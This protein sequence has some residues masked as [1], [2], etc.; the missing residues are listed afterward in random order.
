M[1]RLHITTE[2][3]TEQGFVRRVLAE[4]LAG[5]HVFV[6]AR[7]ILTSRDKRTAKEY[8]GG[9]IGYEKAKK[10][11]L[12][13]IKEDNHPECRFTTM[14]DLYALPEDFPG[15]MVAKNA[16]D[17]YERTNVLE[18]AMARDIN[19]PRFIPYIQLHEFEALILS[20]PRKLDG[21]YLEHE[22]QIENLIAMVDG[23][24]PELINDDPMTAPSK[25]II[26]EIPEYD[27][28]SAGVS[29]AAKIGLQALRQRC[30]HFNAWVS[31]LERLPG[32]DA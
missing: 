21:E 20:D 5:F 13:W 1:I 15:Y 6:D 7:C 24:N 29:V 19:D 17:P 27:K 2:G 18:A 32:G 26:H 12:A 14:F 10:D 3:Q 31:S 8:R 4:H 25:R 22:R 9:L 28:V 11:I 30:Q 16:T 23:K